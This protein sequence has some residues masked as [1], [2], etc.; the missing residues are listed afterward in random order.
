MNHLRLKSK[1]ILG[2]LT[3]LILVTLISATV[4]TIVINSQYRDASSRNITK[5]INIVRQDLVAQLSAVLD[6]T[7]QIATINTMGAKVK[8]LTRYKKQALNETTEN[9]YK[10]ITNDILHIG[11]ASNLWQTAVYDMEGDVFAFAVQKDDR[12]F[13]IAYAQNYSAGIFKQADANGAEGS[14]KAQWSETGHFEA[15]PVALKYKEILPTEESARVYTLGG[16]ICLVSLVPIVGDQI[17]KE[18]GE[19]EKMQFGFA[20]TV[21]KLDDA[22]IGRMASLTGMHINIFNLKGFGNGSLP[23]YQQLQGGAVRPVDG[24]WQLETQE[25]HLSEIDLPADAYFQGVL[26]LYAHGKPIGA[27]A[28]LESKGIMRSN[29]WQMIKLLLV[30][31]IGCIVFILPVTALLSNSLAKPILQMVARLKDIAEGEGDLT[32]RLDVKNTDELGELAL[33]F[34]TFIEKLQAMMQGIAGNA[35]ILNG[36]SSDFSKLSSQMS[37]GAGQISTKIGAITQSAEEMSASLA[38]VAG[39]MEE[40]ATNVNVMAAAMEE[41]TGTIAE[42]A[43]NSET[44]R[45]ITEDAV[46]KVKRSSARVGQLGSAA[47]DISKVTETITNVSEQTNLLALN[48][49][50]EAARAGEAGKGFAVVAGEIKELAKQTAGATMDIKKKIEDIQNVSKD[51]VEDIGQILKV[52]YA[53]NEIVSTTAAAVEQQ[54]TTAKEIARNVSQAAGGIQQVN[55]NLANSNTVAQEIS[56]DIATINKA[57]ENMSEQSSGIS[58]R[59]DRIS[60]L[61]DELKSMVGRFRI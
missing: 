59:A 32:A 11:S 4:V 42:I 21:R 54:S 43:E 49:T 18:T 35:E 7:R 51:A 13:L 16:H 33:W 44:S 15:L 46:D 37:G 31:S 36:A 10:E 20:M 17:S 50:I 39:A 60:Q 57:T 55:E 29:T 40:T 47:Q 58:S 12:S 22:F 28:V 48:A 5:S 19:I 38:S 52:I 53:V 41:M 56:R 14:A 23:A 25:I 9:V 45:Q 34:N 30:V 24:D 27:I 2:S 8:F 3:M 1:L 26:P 61:A 6:T